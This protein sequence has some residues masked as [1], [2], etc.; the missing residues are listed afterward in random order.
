[1]G[2]EG[3]RDGP[4]DGGCGRPVRGSGA[5]RT[6]PCEVVVDIYIVSFAFERFRGVDL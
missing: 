1:M 4:W 6:P 2:R 5:R 3:R